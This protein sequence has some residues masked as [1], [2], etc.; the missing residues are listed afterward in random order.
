MKKVAWLSRHEMTAEQAE[1]LRCTIG[2]FEIVHVENV[3]WP[4]R[5]DLAVVLKWRDVADRVGE[6][7][8]ICGVF[9]P[10]ATSRNVWTGISE[11][12][13]APVG[14]EGFKKLIEIYTPV[15]EQH[16]EERADGLRQI[17]FRHVRWVEL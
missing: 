2:E 4:T 17:E 6:G 7:G 13:I 16:A 11:F 1:D 8:V 10:V 14:T 12:T 15:S 9:P 5:D 3:T